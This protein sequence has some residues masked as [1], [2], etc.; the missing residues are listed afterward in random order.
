[1]L[2]G[3]TYSIHGWYTQKKLFQMETHLEV[4]AICKEVVGRVEKRWERTDWEE[5]IDFRVDGRRKY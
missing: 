3:Y 1:M 4:G 5:A 2:Y